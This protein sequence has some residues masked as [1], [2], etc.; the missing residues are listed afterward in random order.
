[1]I[2]S[3]IPTDTQSVLDLSDELGDMCEMQVGIRG[4]YSLVALFCE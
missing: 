2:P 3:V 4:D 1:M